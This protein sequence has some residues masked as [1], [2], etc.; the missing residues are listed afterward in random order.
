MKPIALSLLLVLLPFGLRAE[1]AAGYSALPAADSV[2]AVSAADAARLPAEADALP[3]KTSSWERI[4]ERLPAISGYVQLGYE[5][6]ERSSTF[7]IKRVRLNLAGNLA[8]K[9]G[10]RVQIEFASPKVVDAYVEW[11]PLRQLNVKLGEYKV[12]FSIENTDYV[13]LKFELIEYPLGLRRLMGFEDVCGLSATGRD[14]GATLYGG[15]FRRDG[16]DVLSYDLGVFNGEGINT[17][18]RNTS[19]DL[20]ARLGVRPFPGLLLSASYYRGEYGV[21]YLRRVRYGAGACYDRGP[22]VLRGEWIGGE[23]GLPAGD[24]RP[25]GG[26]LESSGWYDDPRR[27][28]QELRGQRL[29]TLRPLSA[30]GVLFHPDQQPDGVGSDLP[31]RGERHR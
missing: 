14:M 21:S 22:V 13:P 4:L 6:A 18:D 16:Y 9:L 5:A 3:V 19:K 1:H 23:T 30:D 8:P 24:E 20:S 28:D 7:F 27:P 10:Y 12:P 15:F 29:Q 26:L 11:K 31:R 17:K 25:A 2:A